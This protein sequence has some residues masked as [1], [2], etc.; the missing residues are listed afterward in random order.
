MRAYRFWVVVILAVAGFS[1]WLSLGDRRITFLGM[2]REVQ[3]VQGLDLQGGSRVLLQVAPGT[4]FDSGTMEQ[5]VRN[6]ERRVN[7][8]GV[9]DAVVQR[10]GEDRIIVE[11]PG[12]RE[13][14]VAF[15]AIKSTGLLEFV[16][17]STVIAELPEGA[18]LLTT[19]QIMLTEARLPEGATP[20]AYSEYTCPS[21]DPLDPTE[22]PALL[23]DGQPYRTIMTGA[24]LA[25]A[26]ASTQGGLGTD[27]VVNFVI[28]GG[29]DRVD[30]F[31]RYVANNP[32]RPMAIV[33]DGRLLSYPTI[34]PGLSDAARAG[35]MDGG[36]ITGA[37]TRNEAH[38]LAAQLKYGALPVP[39]DI[40][41]FD[42]IGP[43][44][45]QISVDRS[46]RAGIIGVITVLIFMLV[47]YRVPGIAAGLA[48]LLFIAV[49]FALYKLIPVTLSLPAITGFLI[50]I[51]TAVDGNILIFERMKEELR[52]GRATD[53]AI[54]VGFNRAWTSIRD[55][56]TSTII[57]T[58]ILYFFGSVFGAGAVQGFAITLGMGLVINL[59][60][61]VIA[62]RTFLH[63]IVLVAGEQ[64][65]TRS[66]LLGV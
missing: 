35:T 37:F 50:S 38:I 5:A 58:I 3:V 59:F 17:F 44:L 2:E 18:C 12:V 21:E 11:L 40:V 23:Q 57:I 33:L 26:A 29:G 15:D 45:G 42:T 32:N 22:E 61:A 41:A 56:N 36:I 43:S 25:D 34:Q 53:R 1:S 51:G 60:T 7:G 8:L 9:T 47:Y 62:T 63:T 27:W 16:D 66:R 19:E 24:G 52:K 10:Q 39:L 4:Q 13:Q 28:R 65:R 46:I 6:V 49:N 31:V 30:D 20:P 64:L 14:A 54:E 48:L 55:S